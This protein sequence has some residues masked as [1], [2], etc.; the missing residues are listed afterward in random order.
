MRSFNVST[1]CK[2]FKSQSNA[3]DTLIAQYA[4]LANAMIF[5]QNVDPFINR[6][7][8]WLSY[9]IEQA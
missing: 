5:Y 7:S 1:A 4:G 3:I 6:L 8:K 9:N 2:S